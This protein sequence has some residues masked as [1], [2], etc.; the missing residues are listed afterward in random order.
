MLTDSSLSVPFP[1]KFMISL[2]IIIV[3]INNYNSSTTVI[4]ALMNTLISTQYQLFILTTHP[5][6]SMPY[7]IGYRRGIKMWPHGPKNLSDS[8]GSDLIQ[9][10]RVTDGPENPTAMLPKPGSASRNKCNPTRFVS[11]G[12]IS[13]ILR[14]YHFV[15]LG[16]QL[17]S[18]C[19]QHDIDCKTLEFLCNKMRS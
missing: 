15:F 5:L 10:W 4:I 9:T 17:K 12:L 2:N 1:H 7:Y 11:F 14:G 18:G 13:L 6:R 19:I 3:T 16:L 8:W